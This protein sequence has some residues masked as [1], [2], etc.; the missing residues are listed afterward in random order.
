MSI[1]RTK[2]E[3]EE[4]EVLY[5]AQVKR[6]HEFDSGDI[7][8]DVVVNGVTIYG[9]IYKSGT[10]ENGEEY[11]FVAFPSRKGKDGKY[12]NFVYFK[13]NDDLL[14]DIEKQIERLL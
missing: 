6:V 10:N 8:F 4:Q 7:G 9:C 12:Y 14:A 1:N 3:S 2:N 13:I 11:T 5:N